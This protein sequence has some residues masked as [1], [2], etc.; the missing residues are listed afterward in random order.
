MN[1][2]TELTANA[3]LRVLRKMYPDTKQIT[4]VEHGYD[5]IVGLLDNKYAVR[6]PRNADAYR[7]SQYESLS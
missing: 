7:R 1:P 5:N 6:F 2:N 4:I 3:A